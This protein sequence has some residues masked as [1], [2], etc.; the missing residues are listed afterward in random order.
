MRPTSS[1]W[2]EH[3]WLPGGPA[4]SV[5]VEAGS[6]GLIQNVAVGAPPRPE[7][8][9]LTG[10]VLP[11]TGTAAAQNAPVAAPP[12]AGG[13]A[14]PAAGAPAPNPQSSPETCP[15]KGLETVTVTWVRPVPPFD[16]PDGKAGQTGAKAPK[17][18]K[19]QGGGSG[20]KEEK[21][22]I[23]ELRDT[24]AVTVQGLDKLLAQERCLEEKNGGE[25]NIIL[26]LDRRPLPDA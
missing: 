13:A 24:I 11:M 4:A 7:D 3:A 8:V 22:P 10:L 21:W 6:N 17:R 12:G 16:E 18:T 25:R 9:R 14:P 1:W 20:K 26:Y 5:R 2:C 19:R 23:V 15:P